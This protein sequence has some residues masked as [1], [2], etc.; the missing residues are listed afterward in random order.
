MHVFAPHP[1]Q[2]FWHSSTH[3]ESHCV[4]QQYESMAQTQDSHLHPPQP[5]F[6]QTVQPSFVPL[7]PLFPES[8]FKGFAPEG[9]S[10]PDVAQS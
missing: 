9:S 1:P 7:L 10:V 8:Q 6:A 2:S 5:V 4:W 3:I